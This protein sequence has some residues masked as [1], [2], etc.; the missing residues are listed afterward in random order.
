MSDLRYDPVKQRWTVIAPERARRPSDFNYNRM[1]IEDIEDAGDCPFCPGNE[2]MTTEEIFSIKNE[3]NEG[4]LLRVVPNMYPIF[5]VEGKIERKGVGVYD[6]INGIGAHEVIIETPLHNIILKDYSLKILYNL[7]YT[8]KIRMLDLRRDIRFRYILIFKNYGEKAGA[9]LKHQHSQIIA[10][11]VM[12]KMVTTMLES[13]KKHYE[14]KERC[15][16][17]D[18]IEQ[19]LK[20]GSRIVYEN[21]DFVAICPYASAFPFEVTVYPRKHNHD[22]A[23]IGDQELS[24]L[25]DMTREVFIRLNQVLI[26][27]AL[28]VLIHSAPPLVERPEYPG[29]WKSLHVDYHW[30]MEITPRFTSFAGFEGGTGFHINPVKPEDSAKFLRETHI[31]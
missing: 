29:Y 20:E 27:P 28:N 1:P 5:K 8:F 17:C 2:H 19:E 22:F 16:V 21:F 30:H 10:L 15:L 9:T 23:S 24:S 11:P 13:T 4:W 7:F 12:P 6:K 3:N 18:I 14:K 26:N 25:A 31:G